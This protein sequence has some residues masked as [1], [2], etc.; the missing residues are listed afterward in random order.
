MADIVFF[1]SIGNG[2]LCSLQMVHEKVWEIFIRK[3]MSEYPQER[4]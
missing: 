3:C 2:W 1:R 4:I